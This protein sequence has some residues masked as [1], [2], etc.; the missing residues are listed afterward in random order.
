M[1]INAYIQRDPLVREKVTY[2]KLVTDDNDIVQGVVFPRA[3]KAFSLISNAKENER[4][5]LTGNMQRDRTGLGTQFVIE[6]AERHVTPEMR[7]AQERLDLLR[8][9][10]KRGEISST[11]GAVQQALARLQAQANGEEV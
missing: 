4:Y 7:D 8:A 11:E 10:I 6:L 9:A 2:V 5:V 1:K 3:I